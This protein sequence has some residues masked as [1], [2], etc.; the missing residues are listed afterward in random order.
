M[1]HSPKISASVRSPTP[2]ASNRYGAP[3]STTT[4]INRITVDIGRAL[5][6]DVRV[7]MF[8]IPEVP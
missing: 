8:I 4:L 5:S 6:E 7:R 1:A 2:Y 3:I